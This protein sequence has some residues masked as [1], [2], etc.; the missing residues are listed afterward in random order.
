MMLTPTV[1]QGYQGVG[2]AFGIRGK[3]CTSNHQ[4]KKSNPALP[5]CGPVGCHA[6]GNGEMCEHDVHC[7]GQQGYRCSSWQ[8]CTRGAVGDNC[9]PN[10]GDC[11]DQNSCDQIQLMCVVKF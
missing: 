6:G 1:G 10:E 3:A 11:N 8:T 7:N 2:I 9:Q 5:Y 4:C